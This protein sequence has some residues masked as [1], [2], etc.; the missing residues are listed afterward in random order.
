M[1][2]VGES[3][4]KSLLLMDLILLLFSLNMPPQKSNKEYRKDKY[5]LVVY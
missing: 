2:I 1:N 5:K 4:E 3:E